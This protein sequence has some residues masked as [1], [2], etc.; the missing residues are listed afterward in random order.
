MS[1]CLNPFHWVLGILLLVPEL[2]FGSEGGQPVE[3]VKSSTDFG[4]LVDAAYV[5]GVCSVIVALVWAS[6]LIVMARIKAGR[7]GKERCGR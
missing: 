4:P 6:G 3:A 7:V 1:R 2:V 5:C